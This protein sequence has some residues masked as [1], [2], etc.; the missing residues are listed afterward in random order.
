MPSLEKTENFG[1]LYFDGAAIATVAEDPARLRTPSGS[2]G[3]PEGIFSA[4]GRRRVAIKSF[5][6]EEPRVLVK[7]RVIGLAPI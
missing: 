1:V 2:W 7:G 5:C 6:S 3:A 4:R